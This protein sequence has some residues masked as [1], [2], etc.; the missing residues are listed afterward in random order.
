MSSVHI[1]QLYAHTHTN[2]LK[3]THKSVDT[4]AF[5]VKSL[6]LLSMLRKKFRQTNGE[7]RTRDENQDAKTNK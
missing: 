7:S 3:H 6:S 5:A 1:A 4:F 2:S